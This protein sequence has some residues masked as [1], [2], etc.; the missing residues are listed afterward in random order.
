MTWRWKSKCLVNKC[1]L[2]PGRDNGT[3]R[4]ILTN[5]CSCFLPVHTPSP[6]YSY[7]SWWLLPWTGPPFIF[8]RK[9]MGRSRFF[10]TSTISAWNNLHAKETFCGGRFCSPT[11]ASYLGNATMGSRWVLTRG[12]R[13]LSL[14]WF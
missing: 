2:G 4:G 9:L 7:L 8:L 5:R 12:S 1:L 3:Q 14:Q 10:W 13:Y 11:L 6:Y